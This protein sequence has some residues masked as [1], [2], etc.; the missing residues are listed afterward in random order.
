[1]A[2]ALTLALAVP[3]AKEAN[4]QQ[5]AVEAPFRM[6][7]ADQ[8]IVANRAAELAEAARIYGYNLAA[9]KWSSE[10]AQCAALPNVILLHYRRGFSDGAQ[11]VFTAVVPR[12]VGRVRIVPVLYHNATPFVRAAANPRDY[13]LFNQ[14]VQENSSGGQ[15][16]ADSRLQLSACYAELAGTDAGPLPQADIGIASAPTPTLHLTPQSKP[17][18]VTLASRA[19]PDAYTVWSVSFNQQGKV[20]NVATEEQSVNQ[21]KPTENASARQVPTA[22]SPAV[23][24]GWRYISR[25]PDPPSKMIPP[26]PQPPEKIVPNA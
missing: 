15:V 23:E 21:G 24:P 18:S 17:S 16:G 1:M 12:S 2:A 5:S 8:G 11:S 7:V 25:P 20:T 26:A 10:Q 22:Q 3:A 19:H 6:S 13:A 4:A 9:G 14:L